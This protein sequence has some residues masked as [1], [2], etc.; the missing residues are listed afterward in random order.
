ML[1]ASADLLL[2][3]MNLEIF[4]TEGIPLFNQDT[5]KTVMSASVGML[6]DA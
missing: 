2:E 4:D 1:C 3:G 6:G 5:C